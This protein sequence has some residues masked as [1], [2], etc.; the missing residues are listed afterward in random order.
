[1]G[2]YT[3]ILFLSLLAIV[4]FAELACGRLNGNRRRR[5]KG[6]DGSPLYFHHDMFP[7]DDPYSGDSII[8]STGATTSQGMVVTDMMVT[9]MMVTD[10]MV[11]DMMVTDMVAAGT[12]A[13]DIISGDRKWR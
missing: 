10:M 3:I 13:V 2:T 7:G 12:M 9:D 6:P 1:M 11:T 5:V 8:H 4:G